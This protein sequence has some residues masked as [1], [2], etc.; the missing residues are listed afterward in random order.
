MLC[1]DEP[2]VSLATTLLQ[3]VKDAVVT[4]RLWKELTSDRLS[5][6]HGTDFVLAVQRLRQIKPAFPVRRL[7][8]LV[9][10]PELLPALGATTT[11]ESVDLRGELPSDFKTQIAVQ[12]KAVPSLREIDLRDVPIDAALDLLQSRTNWRR[13][14][15][16]EHKQDL[17]KAAALATHNKTAFRL[18]GWNPEDS[19]GL[20]LWLTNPHLT[21]LHIPSGTVSLSVLAELSGCP[22]LTYLVGWCVGW[23]QRHLRLGLL[24]LLLPTILLCSAP[25]SRARARISDPSLC[26]P[27]CIYSCDA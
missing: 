19:E 13:I 25:G 5:I 27:L 16:P 9:A 23:L 26:G 11:L 22:N 6:H 8:M 12:L 24:L 18:E 15:L 3:A 10:V 2:D 20:T 1:A 14:G 21:A 4:D 17:K 7:N